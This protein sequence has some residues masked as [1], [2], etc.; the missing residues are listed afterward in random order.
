MLLEK[1]LSEDVYSPTQTSGLCH[2]IVGKTTSAC[3]MAKVFECLLSCGWA[4][5][6]SS[7]FFQLA[8]GKGRDAY[9]SYSKSRHNKHNHFCPFFIPFQFK[10]VM[11]ILPDLKGI[12][13]YG[14]EFKKKKKVRLVQNT[15]TSTWRAEALKIV[16]VVEEGKLSPCPCACE[17]PCSS[18]PSMRPLEHFPMAPGP[19][20]GFLG[21]PHTKVR[22]LNVF[23]S[24]HS[25]RKLCERGW[26]WPGCDG[27]IYWVKIRRRSKC[28]GKW[29]QRENIRRDSKQL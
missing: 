5:G 10:K 12:L 4:K 22:E 21:R 23:S 20:V 13:E 18:S 29:I 24:C 11:V 25:G 17:N 19:G 16:H 7:H 1:G 2:C 8:G 28:N 3:L 6:K 26:G 9:G 14:Y 27:S 15:D